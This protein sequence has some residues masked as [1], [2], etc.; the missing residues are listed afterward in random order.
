MG[1][2]SLVSRALFWDEENGPELGGG[3]GCT[4]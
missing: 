3:D 1:S 4:I 2:D